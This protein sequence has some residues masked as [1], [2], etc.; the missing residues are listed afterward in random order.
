MSMKL[1]IYSLIAL[2]FMLL[3]GIPASAQLTKTT[4]ATLKALRQGKEFV[5]L[6]NTAYHTADAALA[7]QTTASY[8]MYTQKHFNQWV[9][10]QHNLAAIPFSDL[11]ATPGESLDIRVKR[12]IVRQETLQR[13]QQ[14]KQQLENTLYRWG[15]LQDETN[16]LCYPQLARLTSQNNTVTLSLNGHTALIQTRPGKTGQ[17][18]LFPGDI[19]SHASTVNA[20][21]ESYSLFPEVLTQDKPQQIAGWF[22][23]KTNFTDAWKEFQATQE[24]YTALNVHRGLFA[25]LQ[26]RYARHTDDGKRIVQNYHY[27]AAN[28]ALH[29]AKILQFM[30]VHNDLFPQVIP[31]YK[32]IMQLNNT[33]FGIS[34]SFQ[35][36]WIESLTPAI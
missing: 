30:S 19:Q 31:S 2:L 5:M 3:A 15:K 24:A 11:S 4:E 6:Y 9:M 22:Y 35:R 33:N 16:S 7:A 34:P 27:A 12:S 14:A 25:G 36:F 18:T 20:L 23:L 17:L 32:Q 29:S 8:R 26:N 28:L 10:E 1:Y 21:L 13:L